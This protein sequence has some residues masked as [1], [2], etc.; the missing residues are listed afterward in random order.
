MKGWRQETGDR[1]WEASSPFLLG[2]CAG[3]AGLLA[4]LPAD[5]VDRLVRDVVP[6][7]ISVAAVLAGFQT[8]AQSLMLVLIDTPAMKALR[9]TGHYEKLVGFFWASMRTLARFIAFALVVMVCD[10]CRYRL[11]WHERTVPALLAF[12]FVRAALTTI[13][14][15]RLT[16]KL[17]LKKS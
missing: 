11:P 17:L 3:L 15:G 13:R 1:L 16:I 12:S 4:R 7:A 9:A 5:S 10:A 6:V 8:T 14:M 2:L